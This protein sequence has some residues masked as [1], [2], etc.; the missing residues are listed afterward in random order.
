MYYVL[1]SLLKNI[2]VACWSVT[3]VRRRMAIGRACTVT[4]T[5]LTNYPT[6]KCYYISSKIENLPGALM[7]YSLKNQ[8]SIVLF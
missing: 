3:A 2:R 8:N 1:V 4:G 7:R 6:R 5:R